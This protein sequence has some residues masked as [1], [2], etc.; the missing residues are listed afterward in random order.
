MANDFLTFAGDPAADVMPQVD[1]AAVAFTTRLLGFSTGTAI[2]TQLNKVW[3]QSSL[4]SSMLGSFIDTQT[5][6][7]ALDDGTPAG[8]TK[9]QTDFTQAVKNAAVQVIDVSGFLPLTGGSLSGNLTVNSTHLTL[10]SAGADGWLTLNRHAGSNAVIMGETNGSPRWMLL[11]PTNTPETGA[12]AGSNLTVN[13]F[14]DAGLFLGTTLSINRATGVVDFAAPPTVGGGLMPY[15]PIAGGNMTGALGVGSTGVSYPGLGGFWGAHHTAFGWDGTWMEM[16][17][18]GVGRG[19]IA[20]VAWAQDNLAGYLLLTGG[21]LSGPLTVASTLLVDSTIFCRSAVYFANLG[22][23]ANF[24]DGR[25]RYR[26]WAG[27]WYDAWDDQS[28]T[29]LW[30]CYGGAGMQ[31]DGGASLSLSGTVHAAG[32]RMMTTANGFAPCVSAY[33]IDGGVCTGFWSD[34]NGMWLGNIDGAGNPITPH[35]NIAN[36]GYVAIYG[37]V[38]LASGGGLY[39]T[40]AVHGD[41][42]I[43]GNANA[44]IAG[45]LWT[46]VLSVAGPTYCNGAITVG[47]DAQINGNARISGGGLMVSSPG[48]PGIGLWSQGNGRAFGHWV[49]TAMMWGAMDGNGQP[50]PPLGRVAEDGWA[51]SVIIWAPNHQ[52]RSA[53]RM[54]DAEL[55]AIPGS[56]QAFGGEFGNDLFVDAGALIAALFRRVKAL[57]EKLA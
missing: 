14:S 6:L 3:R 44:S 33:S 1:Y 57:E 39:A 24:Y 32:G 21:T 53:G 49:S 20:T 35:M 15:V 12:N 30:A 28:G 36:G 55:D 48:V 13:R 46:G 8:M 2:S 37:G 43:T 25:W 34:A 5:G 19:Q 27:S 26:Q 11:L 41:G 40:G 45:T 50:S 17:V 51:S 47:G 38:T 16:A 7:G 4:M 10:N 18:D 31:L 54:T 42:D 23:F 22:D 29:R 9:L 52:Y 56:R